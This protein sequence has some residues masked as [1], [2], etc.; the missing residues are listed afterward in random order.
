[1]IEALRIVEHGEK[2]RMIEIFK[3]H[4]SIDTIDDLKM[5]ESIL[6]QK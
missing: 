2:I 4:V 3:E 1:M 6:K 5:A